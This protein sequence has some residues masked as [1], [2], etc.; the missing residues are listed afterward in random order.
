M[1]AYGRTNGS[2]NR[3]TWS[4]VTD[5]ITTVFTN[6]DWNPN[7]GWYNNSFRTCGTTQYAMINFEPF[8]R[9]DQEDMNFP[10][11]Y[12]KTIEVDFESEKVNSSS[13]KLIV[14]GNPSAA[15]IEITPNT[16]TLF[17]A[18]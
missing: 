14:I 9:K 1:S 17:D 7:S 12:G 15:H 10:F 18:R 13:D 4:D 6:I 16:A 3:A 5:T 2:S 8:L 11:T